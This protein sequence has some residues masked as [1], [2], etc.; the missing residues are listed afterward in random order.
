VKSA[1]RRR[2]DSEIEAV[3]G[4]RKWPQNWTRNWRNG[5]RGWNGLEG[6]CFEGSG[7]LGDTG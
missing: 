1:S 2:V 3:V 4:G 7:C 6:S 5:E